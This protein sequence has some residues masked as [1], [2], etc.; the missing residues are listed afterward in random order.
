M[1]ALSRAVFFSFLFLIGTI[2]VLSINIILATERID[3]NTASQEKLEKITGVGPTIAQRIMD[4]RPFFSVQDLIRVNGIGEKTLEKIIEQGLASVSE[5]FEQPQSQEIKSPSTEFQQTQPQIILSYPQNNPVNKEVEVFLSLSNF[6]NTTYDVKISIEREKVLSNIYNEIEDK[7]QSSHYY[8]NNLFT[9][10][11][12]EGKFNLKIREEA[13][14]FEGEADILV[15]VRESEKSNYQEHKEKINIIPP[16]EQD[17]SITTS[18]DLTAVNQQ[19]SDIFSFFRIFLVAF[20]LAI[21]SGTIIFS[22]K[23]RFKSR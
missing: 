11:F 15:R 13:L 3:I 4:E 22:L 14:N 10:S 8:I 17:L 1:K 20:L 21:F 9:G 12:F 6:K 16:K 2:G 7:W 23:R 5:Q 18:K 19:A